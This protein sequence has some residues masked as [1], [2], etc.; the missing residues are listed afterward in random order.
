VYPKPFKG[1]P[2]EDVYKFVQEFKEAIAADQVR[3]KD[4]VKTLI[5][6]LMGVAK[7]TIG[8]YHKTLGEH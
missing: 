6:Y 1:A 8:E 4:K 3:T 7:E 2:G 5:R